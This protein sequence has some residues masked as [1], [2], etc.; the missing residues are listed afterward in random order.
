MG[1]PILSCAG[2][3]RMTAL[4]HIQCR[5]GGNCHVTLSKGVISPYRVS[6]SICPYEI[7]RIC[8]HEILDA[9]PSSPGKSNWAGARGLDLAQVSPTP[10]MA[11]SLPL[12]P[13]TSLPSPLDMP[14]FCPPQP[15]AS[16][17]LPFHHS[18]E[19]GSVQWLSQFL[20]C[21]RRTL[22]HVCEI[23]R[24]AQGS[25]ADQ[26]NCTLKY[27]WNVHWNHTYSLGGELK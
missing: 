25:H 12:Q 4:C 22:W 26:M 17:S 11:F 1:S 27:P 2:I 16:I 9:N 24:P 15:L 19:A 5:I 13:A 21:H 7:T 8:I 6:C 20:S 3:G 18:T 23:P 14:L 10:F